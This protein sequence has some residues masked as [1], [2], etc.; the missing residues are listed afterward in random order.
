MVQQLSSPQNH[1]LDHQ[2]GRLPTQLAHDLQAELPAQPEVSAGPG[3]QLR[4]KKCAIRQVVVV[5][6]AGR[7]GEVVQDLDRVIQLILADEPRGVVCDLSGVF[8]GAE[9]AA[10]DVLATAG[11]HVRDW[12][13][14][15]VA[16]ACPD[17]WLRDT[18][19]AHLLGGHLIV[20]ESLFSAR[21]AVLAAPALNVARLRLA[22]HP[23]A[24]REA[25]DF[26]GRTLAGWRLSQVIPHAALVVSE[27]LPS[28][29][30]S[31]ATEVDLSVVWDRGALRLTVRDHGPAVAGQPHAV[32]GLHGRGLVVVAVL[33]RRFGVL[34]TA[35][36]GKVLW[37]V[38]E[39][40]WP[41]PS[42]SNEMSSPRP[43]PAKSACLATL[44][45][46]GP[47]SQPSRRRQRVEQPIGFEC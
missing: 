35:S 17:P 43:R 16:V 29:S 28:P 40:P 23:T 11:R 41:R 36:G 44:P 25:R 24:P 12:P 14:I 34:P 26:V 18:L 13:G 6:V 45:G 30:D 37:A 5:Q 20:T 31:E 22:L 21:N 10:V 27:L 19:R 7:L 3:P 38:L 32:L 9:P 39:A 46:H 33:S 2:V 8:G 1:P 42:T 4:V 47:G 15:P